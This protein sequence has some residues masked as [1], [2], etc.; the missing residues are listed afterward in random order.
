MSI[1]RELR[2]SSAT[3]TRA[4][5][6]RR[7]RRTAVRFAGVALLTVVICTHARQAV[8]TL[9]FDKDAFVD[10][11]ASDQFNVPLWL[12]Q[13]PSSLARPDHTATAYQVHQILSPRDSTDGRWHGVELQGLTRRDE[14]LTEQFK[15][16]RRIVA[17]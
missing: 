13:R 3:R 12:S 4:E 16:S 6:S 17:V 7:S 9:V 10:E 5:R 15:R 8:P 14:T 1:G 2:T 11:T